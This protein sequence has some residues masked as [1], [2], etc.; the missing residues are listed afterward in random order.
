M[1]LKNGRFGE[2]TEFDGFSKATKLPPEDKP[3]NPKVSYYNP[4]EMD[5]ENSE[6]R[7]FVLKSLKILGY[8]PETKRPIGIKTRKPGKAFKFVKNIRCG[9]VEIECPSN[10]YKLSQ[11]EQDELVKETLKIE[12][13]KSI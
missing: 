8:H 11:E 6:T 12:N 9:D 3:K 1:L 13:Y 5:Y 10:F 7:L 4:H 2:Y